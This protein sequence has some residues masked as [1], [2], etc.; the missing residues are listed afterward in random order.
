MNVHDMGMNFTNYWHG[1]MNYAYSLEN[2]VLNVFDFMNEI[3]VT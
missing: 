2:I 1:F 3:T